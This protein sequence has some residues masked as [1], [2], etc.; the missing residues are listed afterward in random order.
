MKTKAAGPDE[1]IALDAETDPALALYFR[2]MRLKRA[3]SPRL[4]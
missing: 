1:L 2:L 3:A 4:A